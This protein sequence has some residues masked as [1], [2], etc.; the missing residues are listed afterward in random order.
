METV[1]FS[2]HTSLADHEFECVIV[3]KIQNKILSL[4]NYHEL[5]GDLDL[6]HFICNCI[7][8]EE[9]VYSME[10]KKEFNKQLKKNKKSFFSLSFSE[11]VK[12]F[13]DKY[14]ESD[15]KKSI[16]L[17]IMFSIFTDLT[18][19]DEEFIN[20]Q[21]EFLYMKQLIVR[22]TALQ[23]FFSNWYHY[24]F[25]QEKIIKYQCEHSVP[26]SDDINDRKNI[27]KITRKNLKLPTTLKNEPMVV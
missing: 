21:L 7:E 9:K 11:R 15:I 27:K 10:Q 4:H 16:A 13:D 3:E 26:V 2:K 20:K 25:V 22:P 8:A 14:F 12:H 23:L 1:D 5:K 6:L 19:D 24:L 17:N 18:V